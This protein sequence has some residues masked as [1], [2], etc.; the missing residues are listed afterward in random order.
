MESYTPVVNVEDGFVSI[1]GLPD[2]VRVRKLLV[3]TTSTYYLI[4]R[5]DTD[6]SWQFIDSADVFIGAAGK[7][8]RQAMDV[9]LTQVGNDDTLV[10]MYEAKKYDLHSG[11]PRRTFGLYAG[12]IKV[13][14][15]V[16]RSLELLLINES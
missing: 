1:V 10:F 2:G 4:M 9:K 14:D 5:P 15:N 3:D 13:E 8:M 11:G 12:F 6:V 7:P 16:R